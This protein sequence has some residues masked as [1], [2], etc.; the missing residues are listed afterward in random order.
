MLPCRQESTLE[1]PLR[2]HHVVLQEEPSNRMKAFLTME[3]IKRLSPVRNDPVK[4]ALKRA[5][6]SLQ[7][8]WA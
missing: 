1:L 5:A 6:C 7:E 8:N 4:S 2:M 3:R